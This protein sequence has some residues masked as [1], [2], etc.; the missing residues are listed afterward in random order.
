MINS[1][2]DPIADLAEH[3]LAL[4]TDCDADAISLAILLRP[5]MTP[6][7]HRALCDSLELCPMHI[8]DAAICA[9]DDIDECAHL[10]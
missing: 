5:L 2:N 4:A 6:T 1:T 8:C 7:D 9:D 3:I 10:R